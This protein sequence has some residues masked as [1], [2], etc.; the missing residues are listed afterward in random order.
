MFSQT[1]DAHTEQEVNYQELALILPDRIC[2]QK[3]KGQ[4]WTNPLER[5]HSSSRIRTPVERRRR[6]SPATG[7]VSSLHL[8]N[9]P[10]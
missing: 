2:A 7:T 9:A 4:Y 10:S 1:E 8:Q 6:C 5:T 3:P